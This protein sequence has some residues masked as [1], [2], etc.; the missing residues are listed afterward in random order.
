V[1]NHREDVLTGTTELSLL[2][3]AA[4]SNTSILGRLSRYPLRILPQSL[5]VPILQGPARGKRWIVGAQRH[6]FWLGSYEP[7]MQK[8]IA[9][10]VTSGSVF[11]DIGANVGFYSLLASGLVRDGRVFS[12]EPLPTNVEYLRKH[13]ALNAAENVD[14]MELAISNEVG[15]AFFRKEKTGAMG[16]LEETGSA[17]VFTSTI[18]HLLQENRIA[19]P[20]YIK[21]DIEGAELRALLGARNCFMVHKPTLFLATHSRELTRECSDLLRQW[22]FELSHIGLPGEDRAEV[23]ARP[24]TV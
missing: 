14:V 7:E 10:S 5:V 16:R 23:L 22:R 24:L 3:L 20:S 21:M 15:P 12:F 9:N 18:D 4:L 6:A 17:T 13:L 1:G 2:N 11:Y 19:P 8:T